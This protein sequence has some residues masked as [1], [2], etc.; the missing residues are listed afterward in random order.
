MTRALITGSSGFIGKHL[1]RLLHDRGVGV[2]GFDQFSLNAQPNVFVGSLN[3]TNMLRKG[4]NE[5]KPDVIFHLAALIKSTQ[6]ED[7]YQTNLL[8]T[9]SLFE[10]FAELKQKPKVILAS[11]SAVYGLKSGWDALDENTTLSP[12]THYGV[13]KI[14]QEMAALRYFDS[15]QVPVI[16]LRMFNLIGPGQSA[17]LACSNFAKQIA[18]AEKNGTHEIL[19]GNLESYRDFIDVRDAVQAFAMI[20]EKGQ[21]GEVY[22]VCLGKAVSLKECLGEM[23]AMSTK[24]LS[25][26]QE[27]NLIQKNDLPVQVGNPN[28]IKSSCG[29][30]PQISL[31]ESLTDLLNDW[32]ERVKLD[33]EQK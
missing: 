25:V 24:Q 29:W 9:L 27:A 5:S 16:V 22:N 20:A 28:K 8:G 32:R 14:A 10:T 31:K 6:P 33:V 3:D 30:Y 21:A 26:R 11:S 1:Q 13:S 23:M 12:A 4:L 18:L 7:L 17:Q 2:Y 19:T 15:H